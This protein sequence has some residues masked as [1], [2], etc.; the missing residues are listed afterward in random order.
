MSVWAIQ[1]HVVHRTHDGWVGNIQ[2]PTFNLDPNMVGYDRECVESIVR[3]IVDPLGVA[4]NVFISA[5]LL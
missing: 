4:G 1:C 2:T 5:E 3:H